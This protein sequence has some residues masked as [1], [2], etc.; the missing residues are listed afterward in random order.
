MKFIHTFWTGPSQNNKKD[1]IS[2]KA[3]WLSCE[4]H[5]MSWALSCLQA[6]KV[7]GAI[8]L[9]TDNKGREILIDQLKLPYTHVS[10]DLENKLDDYPPQVWALAKIYT[11]SIQSGPFLHLDGDVYF[12]KKPDELLLKSTLIAQNL[13]KNLEIYRLGLNEIN[14]HFTNIPSIFKRNKYE[15]KDIYASN[16]GILGGY[17]PDFFKQYAR[18]AFEFIADNKKDLEKV[19]T[20]SL[21]FI[22]EQ[23]LFCQLAAE[24]NITVNYYKEMVDN[25]VFKDYIKFDEFPDVD[26]VHP[27]GGFKKYQHVCN[28]V[29]KKLRNDYPEYYYRIID[30]VRNSGANM[31]LA[32]YTSPAFVLN[33]LK[34]FTGSEVI[35]CD[36]FRCTK[37]AIDYLK[38]KKSID[39]HWKLDLN[40]INDII[41]K[42]ELIKDVNEKAC[43]L[44]VY[45]LESKMKS[46]HNLVYT[47]PENVLKLYYRD[48]NAYQDIQQIFSLPETELLK[49]KI[50]HPKIYSIYELFW[51][52][53]YNHKEEIPLVIKNNFSIEKD[54]QQVILLPDLLQKSI[55]AYYFDELDAIIFDL[56]KHPI[57]MES[58]LIKMEDY[59]S[60]EEI[61]DDYQS[62]KKLIFNSI[63]RILYNGVLVIIEY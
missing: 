38:D 56:A 22:F 60:F 20:A 58:V 54:D 47:E 10:T 42:I 21:N 45:K 50:S 55:K 28:H 31:R 16:A 63:R 39:E 32:I 35:G 62:Y 19:N 3:G 40:S 26:M 25:P 1:L 4:Y 5:W 7:F 34:T 2:M 37:A 9:V 14:D 8:E 43:L 27:V 6:N 52:W 36:H 51:N 53:T 61:K 24:R 57:T 11:Y 29:A 13:D 41:E 17:D 30:L 44:E 48:K 18:A 49:V 12:W 15:N 59:F 23:Y 33:E 46:L